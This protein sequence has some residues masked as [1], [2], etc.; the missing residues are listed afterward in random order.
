MDES[1]RV[2]L[3]RNSPANIPGSETFSATIDVQIPLD[4]FEWCVENALHSPGT[5]GIKALLN[6]NAWC[7]PGGNAN[8]IARNM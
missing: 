2:T 6:R 1:C 4:D 5:G 3:M 7:V 8:Q